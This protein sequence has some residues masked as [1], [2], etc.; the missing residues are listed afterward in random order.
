MKNPG[1]TATAPA[2][3]PARRIKNQLPA[4]LLGLTMAGLLGLAPLTSTPMLAAPVLSAVKTGEDI[5]VESRGGT[6]TYKAVLDAKT[7]GNMTEVRLPADGNVIARELN[8]IFFHGAHGEQYTLRGWTGKSKFI[9]ACSMNVISQQAGEIVVQVN[10]ATKGTFKIITNDETLKAKLKQTPLVSYR[11]KAVEIKRT[12]TFMPDRVVE[13]DELVW[14][15]PDME[16]TTFYYMPAFTHGSVQG[17]ARLVKDAVKASF[18]NVGSGGDRLPKG[19]SYPFTAENFLKNGYKVSLRTTQASFELGKSDK[20]FYEK[21][22]QQDWFQ[23]SG[24]MYSLGRHPAG[25]PLTATHEVVFAKA[26]ALAMPPV[27]TIQSPPTEARWMDEKGEVAKYKIGET[28]KLS[29]SAVNSDGSAVPDKD[30]TWE[31]HIDPWWK[32]PAVTLP[33]AKTSYTLPEVANQED[34]TNS[35]NRELLAVIKVKVKGKNGTEAVEPFAMLV[36]KTGR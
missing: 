12:Y 16:M 14:M 31:I 10:V 26:D 18:Y 35:I 13:K 21:P 25:Q 6:V 23:V 36:G 29:A 11:D 1:F 7:G 3:M 27:V 5:V 19:I 24:F 4:P 15:Y 30:I 34:R 9:M 28:V 33:G 8:D 20:Y 2:P 32:T 17:P 22:W